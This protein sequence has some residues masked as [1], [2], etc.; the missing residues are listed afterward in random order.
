M[1][2]PVIEEWSLIT[3]EGPFCPFVDP[4]KPALV[5]GKM[6]GHPGIPDGAVVATAK[7]AGL[8]G[9]VFVTNLGDAFTLGTMNPAYQTQYPDAPEKIRTWPEF[10]GSL[11]PDRG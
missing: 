3:R 4:D 1:P 5:L 11:I 6:H 9:N 7:V 10:Q 2:V 8:K